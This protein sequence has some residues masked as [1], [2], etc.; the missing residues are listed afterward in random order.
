M[1]WLEL[2]AQIFGGFISWVFFGIFIFIGIIAMNGI[3]FG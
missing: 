3:N 2:F 1:T